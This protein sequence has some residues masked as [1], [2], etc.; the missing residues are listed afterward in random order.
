MLAVKF[1][2]SF[3]FNRSRRDESG[4]SAMEYTSDDVIVFDG[5]P[6]DLGNSWLVKFVVVHNF[7][8]HARAETLTLDKISVK[9]AILTN[10][11]SIE[12][13][14]RVKI[15]KINTQAV[16]ADEP[17]PNAPE[18]NRIVI[19]AAGSIAVVVC[20]AIG[21]TATIYIRYDETLYSFA[22]I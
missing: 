18:N 15:V 10:R 14:L 13:E 4:I 8:G 6:K 3:L 5:F 22:E 12:K 9:E 11:K 21:I 7:G 19:I 1:F 17:N 2:S 20:L 16:G